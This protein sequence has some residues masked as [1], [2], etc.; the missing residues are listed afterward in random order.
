MDTLLDCLFS[1]TL[2]S[3][4]TDSF[5]GS[6]LPIVQPGDARV[7]EYKG[8]RGAETFSFIFDPASVSSSISR[9]DLDLELGGG[10]GEGREVRDG[11]ATGEVN[12]TFFSA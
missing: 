1:L 12:L 5:S 8:S 6:D 9:T 11:A 7:R 4:F 2:V 10:M 3:P